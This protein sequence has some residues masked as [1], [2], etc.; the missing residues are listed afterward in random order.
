MVNLLLAGLLAIG[1]IAEPSYILTGPKVFQRGTEE[2][3]CL[4]LSS[5]SSGNVTF[6]LEDTTAPKFE[7]PI[8]S[9]YDCFNLPIPE[10]P[11]NKVVLKFSLSTL[12]S[13]EVITGKKQVAVKR[14]E[15]LTLVQTDKPWY[16]PGQTVKFRVL[17][18]DYH[19]KPIYEVFKRIS[20]QDPAGTVV[21]LWKNIVP[22]EGML[23]LELQLSDE[24]IQGTW[25]IKVEQGS[26]QTHK[27]F[28]V[29]E[30]VLPRFEVQIK[31]PAKIGKNDS[32]FEVEVCATYSYGQPCQMGY[33]LSAVI[34]KSWSRFWQRDW[35]HLVSEP[36]QTE[37]SMTRSYLHVSGKGLGCHKTTI[38][39][40]EFT[41]PYVSNEWY[42]MK[43]GLFVVV[44][45]DGSGIS[46][47][48]TT[49]I[50]LKDSSYTIEMDE[51]D[52]F[53]LGIP[54]IGQVT[55]KTEDKT[56]VSNK[57][58]ELCLSSRCTNFTM[59]EQCKNSTTDK[60]GNIEYSFVPTIANCTSYT[61]TGTMGKAVGRRRLKQV[62]SPSETGMEFFNLTKV[63]RCD[64]V[65]PLEISL[66]LTGDSNDV[67]DVHFQVVSRG[68]LVHKEVKTISFSLLPTLHL[69]E[70]QT[71]SPNNSTGS[72]KELKTVSFS[73]KPSC[74]DAPKAMLMAYTL[75]G[76]GELQT[77]VTELEIKPR[78][79]NDV[80]MK[81]SSS[82]RKPGEK[83]KLSVSGKKNSICGSVVVD[84]SVTFL[85]P[86]NQLDENT[87]FD[88]LADFSI[89]RYDGTSEVTPDYQY[90]KKDQDDINDDDT[91]LRKRRSF[92][93]YGSTTLHQEAVAA[94]DKAGLFVITN[95]KTEI[96]PCF[97]ARLDGHAKMRKSYYRG[98]IHDFD[99]RTALTLDRSSTINLDQT[100]IVEGLTSSVETR[101]FFPETWLWQLFNLNDNGNHVQYVETPH[102]ITT[103]TGRTLCVSRDTGFGMS[104]KADLEVFQLFFVELNLPYS[105][106][107][108]EILTLKVS[109]FN[110]A[111]FS[112]PIA[113]KIRES[114]EY[115]VLSGN[116]VPSRCVSGQSKSTFIFK[117]EPKILGSVNITVDGFLD[118]LFDADCGPET[119]PSTRDTVVK[120]LLVIPEGLPVEKT[121]AGM[122]CPKTFEDDNV[123]IW[124]LELPENSIE[125]SAR[126]WINVVGDIMGPS[127]DGL[128]SLVRLPTGCGEQNMIIFTPIVYL[129]QYLD[130]TKQADPELFQ[131]AIGYLKTG[132]QR[133]LTY[134]HEDG[135][136]SA[137]GKSDKSGSMW[138]TAFVVRSFAGAKDFINIDEND[139]T[140]SRNWILRN[141]MENGC[142]PSIGKVLHSELKGGI[143]GDDSSIG[144][145]AFVLASLTENGLNSS[146]F[147]IQN[148]INCLKSESNL[149]TYVSSLT[150]YALLKAG[151]IEAAHMRMK[152]LINIAKSENSLI[153][154]EQGD[155]KALAVEMTS[156]NLM[157]LTMLSQLKDDNE[158]KAIAYSCVRWIS[159]QRN[160]NGGFY[161]TQDTVVALQALA[162]YTM[163]Y[164]SKDLNMILRIDAEDMEEVV[165]LTEEKKIV[166]KRLKLPTVPTQ[167]EIFAAGQ[168]CAIAQAVLR[169]NIAIESDNAAFN[170]DADISN[171]LGVLA[172]AGCVKYAYENGTSNMAVVDIEIPSGKIPNEDSLMSMKN[173]KDKKIKRIDVNEGHMYIYYD[174]LDSTLQ[175]FDFKLDSEFEVSNL[176]DSAIVV[177]DYYA[178]QKR[179]KTVLKPHL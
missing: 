57:F 49:S 43:I 128:S 14:R 99:R 15:T 71:F 24:P 36:I 39:M 65:K 59:P 33:K 146:D 133:E 114:D 17:S 19:L 67:F 151:D 31:A 4:S 83:V 159:Q 113:L 77:A 137:F 81:W 119:I 21:E 160:G 143:K 38:K 144:L 72:T 85:E 16:K 142:F 28:S 175:C 124:N 45:E 121:F 89:K 7:F 102:T 169:Y 29:K 32:D 154:W 111:Q 60:N 171:D 165:N 134:R 27:M 68:D 105:V 87:V 147:A 167:I 179:A 162:S 138:L 74:L 118:E 34:D 156:Y 69:T 161:S 172:V 55:L 173:N 48:K 44:T 88:R 79:L 152:E 166:L 61:V 164:P 170:I 18:L 80:K 63:Q 26:V 132:Y 78:F 82:Q 129:L 107:R 84:K 177:Y 178:P 37:D 141:Q 3:L 157:T 95:K 106:K 135:S 103:W 75:R 110:Y 115:N 58:I 94:F 86:E 101:T 52:V 120:P 150:A 163:T 70:Y 11:S 109:A 66:M 5:E 30:F 92:G 130:S 23:Q 90:C 2:R 126:A 168:G 20:I 98:K 100:E 155:S 140:R 91:D 12:N 47:N 97:P 93:W 9:S 148:G 6:E 1:C 136:F 13:P 53:K 41:P 176:K 153:W 50:D 64:T 158:I 42:S 56:S 62:Y 25:Q 10:I 76:N 40:S 22:E 96:R 51:A 108:G 125:G 104:A 127:I 54:V 116:E 145:S 122:L 73:Y 8:K 117:I 123:T 112:L 46:F 139:L 149:T 174:S 35:M 131:K